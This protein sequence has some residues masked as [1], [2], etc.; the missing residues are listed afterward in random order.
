MSF[1]PFYY[2]KRF[3][4]NLLPQSFFDRKYK[5]LMEFENQCISQELHARISYY[6]KLK[7][8]FKL[9]ARAQSIDTFRRTKGSE[10]YLDLKDFLHYFPRE[11]SFMYHFGDNTDARDIPTII[12]ARMIG[13]SNENSVLF[14]LNK[15]RHFNW[16]NDSKSF[17]EKQNRL[18]WR[19]GAYQKLRKEFVKQFYDHP[20]CNIGQTNLPKENV[21]W[22]KQFMSKQAQLDYKFIFCPEG[23]DVSTN[24][25]WAMSSNS[26]CFMPRPRHETWFMEGLLEP[27]VHYVEIRSDFSDLEEKIDYYSTQI[28]EAEEIISN[29]HRHVARFQNQDLED[30]LS[31]KILERYFKLSGQL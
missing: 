22:Q 2:I 3:G 20:K 29:A 4:Y 1:K 27:G 6:I 28:R 7:E 8:P 18:V 14:K 21:P 16:V 26:I 17:S 9:G 10:Y 23:N 31:I 5:R 19:G 13:N 30:L 24:L 25:K 15:K 12:K 11:A